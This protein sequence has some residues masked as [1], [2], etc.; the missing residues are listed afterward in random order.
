M[1]LLHKSYIKDTNCSSNDLVHNNL[2]P[3]NVFS[4]YVFCQQNNF[5]LS[6]LSADLY[7]PDRALVNQNITD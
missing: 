4:C 1:L 2:R 5:C 3:V 7:F 6:V